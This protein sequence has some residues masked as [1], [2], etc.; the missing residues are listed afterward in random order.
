MKFIYKFLVLLTFYSCQSN[1]NERVFVGGDIINPINDYVVLYNPNGQ[2]DTLYLNSDNKFFHYFT[3]F[4]N[5]IHSFVHG[6]KY[7]SL[8]LENI[9]VMKAILSCKEFVKY[10]GLH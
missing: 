1:G 7:Q 3:D 4:N 5:G 2:V 10:H 6:G 8:L 9:G